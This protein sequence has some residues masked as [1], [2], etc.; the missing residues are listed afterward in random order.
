MATKYDFHL[1]IYSNC[2]KITAV[3]RYLRNRQGSIS[4]RF[5]QCAIDQDYPVSLCGDAEKSNQ[6]ILI[7]TIESLSHLSAQMAYIT[8][9]VKA[10]RGV[11]I[12]PDMLSN[13]G[14]LP[15]VEYS[16]EPKQQVL[17]ATPNQ[18]ASSEL[19]SID[20]VDSK[21]LSKSSESDDEDQDYP[22]ASVE[23]KKEDINDDDDDDDEYAGMTDE[24]YLK[25]TEHLTYIAP[26]A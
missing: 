13:F 7:A 11:D 20:D 4:Q 22:I 18:P 14:I 1:S 25:A 5:M 24:E 17:P 10:A 9:F 16:A 21:P 23:A 8:N 2:E 19:V 26:T 6:D 3:D 12:T 15:A